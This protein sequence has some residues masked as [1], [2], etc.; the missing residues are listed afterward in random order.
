MLPNWVFETVFHPLCHREKH[1]KQD[2]STICFFLDCPFSNEILLKLGPGL[3]SCFLAHQM[4]L[5]LSG[6]WQSRYFKVGISVAVMSKEN[7]DL[8]RDWIILPCYTRLN[9][10]F[11]SLLS[12]IYCLGIVS[13]HKGTFSLQNLRPHTVIDIQCNW[14]RCTY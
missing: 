3:P 10:S 7:L 9:M 2:Q 1:V 14:K 5:Q 11:L 4:E 12:T 6:G 13:K 8:P